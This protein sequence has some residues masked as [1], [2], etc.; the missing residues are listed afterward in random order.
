[1]SQI[2][3]IFD[4]INSNIKILL[5]SPHLLSIFQGMPWTNIERLVKTETLDEEICVSMDSWISLWQ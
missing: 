4:P 1:M 3:E 2:F 5:T